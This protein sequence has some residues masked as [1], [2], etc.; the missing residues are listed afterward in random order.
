MKK[1]L[2]LV[3]AL[4]MLLGLAACGGKTPT[5]ADDSKTPAQNTDTKPQDSGK[6]AAADAGNA[7][8]KRDT[9]TVATTVDY[10][11]LNAVDLSSDAYG[12]LVGVME[13]LWEMGLDGT[14]IMRLAESYTYLEPDHIEVKLKEGIK[15]SNGSDL[16]ASD[17]M[18]TFELYRD[19]PGMNATQ[20]T[21]LLD[22]ER[23]A[24]R[25]EY[26]IDLYTNV[27]DVSFVSNCGQ[28]FIYDEQTYDADAAQTCP[29]GTGPYVVTD[30][31]V[32]SHVVIERRDDYWGE[33]P[34]LKTITFRVL[35][36]P[37]QR[38]NALE[39]GLVDMA[40][41]AL[42]DVDYVDSLDGIKTISR[43]GAWL[44]LG[45]NIQQGYAM[46]D[47]EARYA[48]CHAIDR[49]AL[50]D[51]VYYGKAT[52]LTNPWPRSLQGNTDDLQN[53][54]VYEKGYDVELAKQYAEK[55]GLV[56]KTLTLANNGSAETVTCCEMI[57]GMLEAIG[58]HTNIVAYDAASFMTVKS[59]PTAY[60]ICVSNGV[61][62]NNLI[63]D[64]FK[65]MDM[66]K[67]FV[68]P[69]NWANGHGDR[70]YEIVGDVFNVDDSIRIPV[71]QELMGYYL[72][73]LPNFGMIGFNNFTAVPEDL[74]T[75][76][77]VDRVMNMYY[78]RDFYFD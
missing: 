46:S 55:S 59:D 7:E 3:L 75:D 40:P 21:R 48:V 39:T 23:T 51:L 52:L 57:Q 44:Y 43:P 45:I 16:T 56:G 29:I 70:Y 20:K 1:V 35:A 5:P 66:N 11:T 73:T 63:G 54:G 41:I 24:V 6:D 53:R 26:T 42:S 27:P 50:S 72:E 31:V 62:G 30:Y 22:F 68:V 2:A 64:S 32:N 36:E 67:I 12:P 28:V 17:V 76:G 77:Y 9:L 58:V 61:V 8:A 10:G 37:S 19:T 74:H 13:S 14:V 15:F 49:Q 33:A 47:P 71:V 34:A 18:F 69:E 78:T 4:V 65:S 38:V 60:D 25:D